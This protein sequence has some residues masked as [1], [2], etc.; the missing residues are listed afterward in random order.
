[1]G[2]SYSFHS[3]DRNHTMNPD[4]RYNINGI[5]YELNDGGDICHVCDKH[6]HNC[7]KHTEDELFNDNQI[8]EKQQ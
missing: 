6:L 4:I 2:L 7:E 3:K 8:E 1:M 5:G